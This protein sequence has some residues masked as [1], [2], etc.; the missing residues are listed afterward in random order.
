MLFLGSKI[1]RVL[2]RSRGGNVSVGPPG[3]VV[4]TLVIA[5]GFERQRGVLGLAKQDFAKPTLD[6]P[7]KAI[8][9]S[10]GKQPAWEYVTKK[11]F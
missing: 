5:R 8:N 6:R 9:P 1:Q 7:L 2:L 4:A 3:L 11:R 10:R